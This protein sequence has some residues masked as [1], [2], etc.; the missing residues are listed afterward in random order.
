MKQSERRS[1]NTNYYFLSPRQFRKELL[2]VLVLVSTPGDTGNNTDGV[3]ILKSRVR[4]ID[5]IDSV[6]D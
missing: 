3:T 4:S 5:C 2:R 1:L 6:L